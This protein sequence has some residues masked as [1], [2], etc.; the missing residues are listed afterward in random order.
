MLIPSSQLIGL[1]V[2][3]A[4]LCSGAP[5]MHVMHEVGRHRNARVTCTVYL[6]PVT[7]DGIHDV[8][9]NDYDRDRRCAGH[10]TV[11]SML[12]TPHTAEVGM[13]G[14]LCTRP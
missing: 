2:Y 5:I 6:Q 8:D 11:K 10:S 13:L 3:I 9:S 14:D 1:G 12:M 4:S 7:A